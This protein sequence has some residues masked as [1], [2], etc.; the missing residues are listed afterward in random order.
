MPFLGQVPARDPGRDRHRARLPHVHPAAGPAGA[1]RRR[2]AGRSTASCSTNGT[3]TSCTI[4]LFVRPAMRARLRAL[5]DR[6]R[7]GS[8]TASA[9]TAWPRGVLDLARQ[10]VRL[11]TGYLY[12][13]AFA[14]LIGVAALVTWYMLRA[15]ERSG[16]E[17]LAAPVAGDLP[18][19][20]GRRLHPA[21]PRRARGRGANARSV[22][23][24]TSPASP[25]CS[26]SCSGPISTPAPAGFQ[27][28]EKARVVRRLRHQLSHRHRRHLAVPSCCSARSSRRSASST[29]GNRSRSGCKEYMVAFLVME[30]LMVGMFCAL[31]FVLFYLFFE[32]DPD[33]DVP[34]HRDL[35]RAAAHLLGLQVLPLHAGRLGPVPDRHPGHVPADRHHRHP[36]ADRG[37][38]ST[39]SCSAGC[40]WRCSP[41]SR[42][43]CRCGRSTP[44]CRTR[45]SRRRPRAR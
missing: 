31:D 1:A 38:A 16:N 8:S 25:S 44:G 21:D 17:R 14:M 32:G 29:P 28:V 7:P 40:G 30:T 45:M 13:Y 42:S 6:R 19:A 24:W 27:L 23:L 36:D 9:R 5:A 18:A 2:G 33:P 10:A 20:G 11:Q 37:R 26:R 34:D 3:S 41:P 39:R 35:G 43:R 4:V 15:S 12:H 22:A